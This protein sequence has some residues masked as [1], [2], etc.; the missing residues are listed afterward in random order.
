VDTD[1]VRHTTKM[2]WRSLAKL[3]LELEAALAKS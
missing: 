2:A 1:G 3:E